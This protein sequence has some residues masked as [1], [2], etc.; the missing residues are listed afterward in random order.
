M[1][2]AE[3]YVG[4]IAPGAEGTPR[5][6]SLS[7]T[8]GLRSA[9]AHADYFDTVS[10]GN[11]FVA[12]NAVAGV[13]PGTVLSTTPPFFLWNPS[14]SKRDLVIL[15]ATI[16]YVSGTLGAGAFGYAYT[17]NQATVPTGGTEIQPNSLLCSAAKGMGRVWTG[18]TL[19]AAPTLL[20]AM[21]SMGPALATT[22][23]FPF[24]VKDDVKGEIIVPPGSALAIQGLGLGTG[25]TP[26]V[27]FSLSWEEVPLA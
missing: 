5:A 20:R 7:R 15:A 27:M 9:L 17:P 19:V 21:G 23:S 13:A 10:R 24:L 4:L 6:V 16:A 12:S 8:G 3:G 18:G 26:L 14:A 1:A 22:V 25:T 2:L 11:A